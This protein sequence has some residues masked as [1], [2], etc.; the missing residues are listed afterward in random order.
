MI[1]WLFGYCRHRSVIYDRVQGR[2]VWRC[3]HC[4]MVK[5]REA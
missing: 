1:A 5:E 4:G 3:W 2:A